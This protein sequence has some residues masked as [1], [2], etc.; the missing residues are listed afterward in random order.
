MVHIKFWVVV[1]VV[2]SPDSV[3]N[4][5]RRY[6]PLELLRAASAAAADEAI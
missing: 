4:G 6:L 3:P 1:V 5:T 2:N